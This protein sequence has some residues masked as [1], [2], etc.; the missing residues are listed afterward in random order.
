VLRVVK[1]NV[2]SPSN[3]LTTAENVTHLLVFLNKLEWFSLVSISAKS[4]ISGEARSSP[5]E[6][7]TSLTFE[8][9]VKDNLAYL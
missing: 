3:L 8:S 7:Y 4:D 5:L 9:V 6:K 2:V 1:L